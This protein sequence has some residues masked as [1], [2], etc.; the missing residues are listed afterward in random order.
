MKRITLKEQ[1]YDFLKQEIISG[2]IKPG[3]RLIEEK[4]SKDLN[5]SRSPIREAVRMLEKDGLLN[6]HVSRG[7]TVITPDIEDYIHLY[8]VRASVES[9]AAYYSAIRRTETELQKMKETIIKMEEAID[10]GSITKLLKSNQSFHEHVLHS[11]HNPILVKMTLQLRGINNFY[12]KAI[13]ESSPFY[14]KRSLDD[15]KRIYEIISKQNA[16]LASKAMREHIDN[17][18]NSFIDLLKNKTIS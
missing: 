16:D 10:A 18:Y 9:L 14:A 1:V 5:V 7:V 2:K 15:H 12:R 13:I 8:E 4:I 17:D 11:S 3:E 6:V